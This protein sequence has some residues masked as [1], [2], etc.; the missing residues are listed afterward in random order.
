M[1]E[2]LKHSLEG[3]FT[4]NTSAVYHQNPFENH[5]SKIPFKSLRDQWVKSFTFLFTW[6]S[7]PWCQ[8]SWYRS[9]SNKKKMSAY[10]IF[11]V[12]VFVLHMLT[13]ITYQCWSDRHLV[14]IKSNQ[15]TYF[16]RTCVLA[17]SQEKRWYSRAESRFAPS[18]WE[19]PLLCNDVS[20]WLGVNLE[21]AILGLRPANERWCYFVTTSLI[22]WV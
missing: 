8:Q 6:P 14:W 2:V 16:H 18:Q 12:K 11:R 3:C 7:K 19:T 4:T 5:L 17:A 10:G 22:G 13:F 1:S 20:H 15:V 9:R 21:S